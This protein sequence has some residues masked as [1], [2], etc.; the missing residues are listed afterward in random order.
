MKKKVKIAYL[1][2]AIFPLMLFSSCGKD[3]LDAKPDKSLVVPKSIKDF[4]ALLDNTALFN[5]G[6]SVGLGEIG[7]GDF[8]VTTATWQS[9]FTVQEKSAYIWAP[10]ATFY[11]GEQSADWIN[12][13]ARILSANVVLY[14]IE[15]IN[16][17]AT[18]EQ[19]WKDVKGSALFFRA[20]DFFNLAQEYCTTYVASSANTDLGLCLR[21][22]YDVNLLSKRSSLQQTYDRILTDL[23]EAGQ[24]LSSNVQYKTRPSKE[25]VYALLGRVYLVMENYERA[26]YYADLALQIQPE[27]VDYNKLNATGT[28][29]IPKLNA[30]VIF[31]NVFSY[32]IFAASKLTVVPEL[33]NDYDVRDQRRSMFFTTNAN[34]MTFKGSYNGDKN[35]F[36]GLATDEMYLI[37]AESAA[38]SGSV[39]AALADLNFLRKNR[40]L[41]TY[42]TV[43]ISDPAAVLEYVLRERRRE[44][45]F[46]GLRWQDLRRL[47]KDSRFAKTLSRVVNGNTYILYPKDSRYVYPLDEEELRLSGIQQNMR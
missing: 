20:Y 13:Y 9:L 26:G 18:E 32:G 23:E 28:F 41:G 24:L 30:E 33:F 29:P 42:T 27:L 2:C 5:T 8:F 44:L 31:Q 43:S 16:P 21:L 39:L 34:G 37:R 40:W 45:L 6:Q 7:A 11:N 1:L 38:R 3:W 36:A 4:Q 35:L 22:D 25:A 12:G 47:N 46:R 14:G 19:S 10:T 17:G 15:Q